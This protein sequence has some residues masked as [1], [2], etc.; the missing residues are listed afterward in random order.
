MPEHDVIVVGEI[1]VPYNWTYAN[2]AARAAA[3]G[4]TSPD[5]GKLARQ[6][7]NN[8]LWMLVATT[9]TWVAVGGGGGGAPTGAAGGDLG[10]TYPDPDVLQV[11][12]VPVDP[13]GAT[14][15]DVL[16]FDGAAFIPDAPAASATPS[17]AAG[18][19][20]GGTYPNPSVAQ[21]QG[22]P[23]DPSAPGAGD[24]MTYDGAAWAP[25][26]PATGGA[27][28]GAAGGDLGG[29]Y[30]NPSVEQV[31]GVPVDPTGASLYDVLAFNGTTFVPAALPAPGGPPTGSA[32]GDLTGT[33][34]SPTIAASAVTDAKVAA[35]NKDGAA[36][37]PSM[38]TLGAGAAQ[39]AA[40]NDARFTD[41]RA[42]SGAAGGDLSGTYPNPGVA[43]V[44]GKAFESGAPAQG[45]M[46]IWDLASTTWVKKP[47]VSTMNVVIDGGGVVITTGVKVDVVVDFDCEIL[48]VTLLAD[49]TGSAVV[50]IWKD[51]FAN[52]PPVVGDK[53]TASAPPTITA[54]ISSNDVTLTGWTKPISAGDILRFNVDSCSA[55][56]RLTLAL[57]L[58]R[59]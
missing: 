41:S 19:D 51:S 36:G 7:D 10:G 23:V 56:T 47:A 44:Q 5:L 29:T 42:P 4:F 40:G 39:A 8:T 46:W 50:N 34:P 16:T 3:T 20:L 17:G 1:H 18:G 55:I 26:A 25:A 37:T 48:G 24:V 45:D 32:G 49:Q 53:I 14:L 30:P 12:G 13:S 21:V 9:P 33:Y 38:R 52:F 6:L 59:R 27:P 58:R 2:A 54:G 35:A 43:K 28:G 15:G 31:N 22:V 57:K 11:N